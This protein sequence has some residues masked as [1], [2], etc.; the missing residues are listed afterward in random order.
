M[1]MMMIIIKYQY[2]DDD[3]GRLKYFKKAVRARPPWRE[4]GGQ[5]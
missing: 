1:T 3:G 2:D 4:R 5:G